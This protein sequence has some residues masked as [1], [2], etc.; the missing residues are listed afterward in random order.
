L[1]NLAS[2]LSFS[3]VPDLA[4]SNEHWQNQILISLK[5]GAN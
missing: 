1:H 3:V 5:T 4:G 2:S